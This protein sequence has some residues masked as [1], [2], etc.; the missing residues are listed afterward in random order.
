MVVLEFDGAGKYLDHADLLAEK[1]RE[2]RIREMGYEVVRIR[3]SD[4]AR[5]GLLRRRILA[6]IAR[7]EE[8]AAV[9]G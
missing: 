4:L 9:P 8:R 6:A 1:D 2:D 7:A 5:P 3:W